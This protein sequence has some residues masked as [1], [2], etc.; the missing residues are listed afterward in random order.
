MYYAII[1][2]DQKDSLSKRTI[3]RAAH[4]KRLYE[5]EKQNRILIAGP[6][7]AVDN[8]DPG[9]KG[10]IGSLIVAEFDSLKHAKQWAKEDPYADAG[11]Y[12]KIIVKP[13]K[14]VF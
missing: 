5:L 7:P 13:F 10:F 14:K 11:V 3:S 1:C 4:L 6:L 8:E 2:K 9:E 12:K